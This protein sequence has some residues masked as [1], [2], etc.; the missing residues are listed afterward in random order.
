MANENE[1]VRD[2]AMRAILLVGGGV[3]DPSDLKMAVDTLGKR[4]QG[5]RAE[6]RGC[7]IAA[8]DLL[9]W[10]QPGAVESIVPAI[11]EALEDEHPDIRQGAAHTLEVMGS[12]TATAALLR[13]QA[14]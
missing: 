11:I 5:P 2:A 13:N 1:G 8:L 3:R 10:F 4:L 9:A 14:R 7:A 12:P 6:A